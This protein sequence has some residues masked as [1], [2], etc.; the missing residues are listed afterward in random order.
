MDSSNALLSTG[1]YGRNRSRKCPSRHVNL[2][3]PHHDFL[4]RCGLSPM[5]EF[6]G[7]EQPVRPRMSKRDSGIV[8]GP[9]SYLHA[10]HMSSFGP[11]LQSGCVRRNRVTSLGVLQITIIQGV[12]PRSIHGPQVLQ[13]SCCCSA[14]LVIACPCCATSESFLQYGYGTHTG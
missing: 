6:V 14:S 13:T 1:K 8:P 12:G 10:A 9:G 4:R 11:Q 3:K 7:H 2:M 5:G